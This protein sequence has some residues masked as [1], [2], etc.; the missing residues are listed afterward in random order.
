M[1]IV[2]AGVVLLAVSLAGLWMLMGW[3]WPLASSDP[4]GPAPTVGAGSDDTSLDEVDETAV[5]DLFEVIDEAELAMLD[6]MNDVNRPPD[7]DPV[8]PT[9]VAGEAVTKLEGLKV[10]LNDVM[11]SSDHPAVQ[12]VGSAYFSHLEDWIDW[13]GAVADDSAILGD[14]EES[15][16]YSEAIGRSAA[17]F[18][19]AVEESFPDRDVLPDDLSDLI[20][21]ILERGFSSEDDVVGD[22]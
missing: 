13:A 4:A 7:V 3:D 5:S 17:G 21:R 18:V 6:F 19:A 11:G 15:A 12:A 9:E 8:V 14:S 16:P 20:D 1:A 10:E 22:I 2:V